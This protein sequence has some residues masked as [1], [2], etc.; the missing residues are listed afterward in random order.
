[1]IYSVTEINAVVVEEEYLCGTIMVQKSL[2]AIV[3]SGNEFSS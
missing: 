3:P 1:V 2:C